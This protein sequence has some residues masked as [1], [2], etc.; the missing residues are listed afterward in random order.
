[1]SQPGETDSKEYV[2]W[3]AQRERIVLSDAG[4]EH[5]QKILEKPPG[6]TSTLKEAVVRRNRR[7]RQ[8]EE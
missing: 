4:F 3:L 6:P 1:M 7:R 5:V 8:S 2:E